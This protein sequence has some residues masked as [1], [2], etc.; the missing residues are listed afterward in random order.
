MTEAR[1]VL[2]GPAVAVP[3]HVCTWN[4]LAG[5]VDDMLIRPSAFCIKVV[6]KRRE[7]RLHHPLGCARD[8]G[9]PS[10]DGPQTVSL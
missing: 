10:E 3:C 4:T 8:S 1:T 6:T 7:R 2:A 9:C 5:G